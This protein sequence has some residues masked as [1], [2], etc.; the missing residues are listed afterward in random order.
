MGSISVLSINPHGGTS[1]WASE[2]TDMAE[3]RKTEVRGR[4]WQS[5]VTVWLAHH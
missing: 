4:H 1:G 2:N 3:G 5:K